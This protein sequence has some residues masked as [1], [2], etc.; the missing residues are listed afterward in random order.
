M[1]VKGPRGKNFKIV[2]H[3]ISSCV[4]AKVES[5]L[6]NDVTGIFSGKDA[7]KG[8][9]TQIHCG[10]GLCDLTFNGEA[11]GTDAKI[12]TNNALGFTCFGRYASCPSNYSPPCSG[13]SESDCTESQ[14]FNSVT[15]QCECPYTPEAASCGNAVLHKF[16]PLTCRCELDCPSNAP[17]ESDCTAMGLLW[18]DCAC[19]TTN[20]CCQTS[21]AN[22]KMWAGYCW[23]ETTEEGCNGEPNGRCIWN[24]TDCLSNSVMNGWS[25]AGGSGPGCKFRDEA[26]TR[27]AVCCSGVC[28]VDGKCR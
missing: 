27:N 9:R 8:Q 25:V 16:N 14:V 17:T 6:A 3:G 20:H 28:R 10:G 22:Y 4:D 26:C 7:G 2:C 24:P 21:I 19:V 15:C 11:A 12:F 23:D 5:Y 18:R 1:L 13:I